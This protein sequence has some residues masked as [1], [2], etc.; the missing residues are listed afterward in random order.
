MRPST[1]AKRLGRREGAWFGRP[2]GQVLPG[3]RHLVLKSRNQ[4]IEVK[5]MQTDNH[6]DHERE[7]LSDCD[8]DLECTALLDAAPSG[9]S[10]W[11][12]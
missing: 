10:Q 5:V 4:P 11:H 2:L 7:D 6:E 9:H 3:E 12:R 1:S 8:H